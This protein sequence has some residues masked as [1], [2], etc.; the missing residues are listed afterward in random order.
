MDKRV[1]I[2]GGNRG[3]GKAIALKLAED[4]FRVVINFKKDN[5]N[6]KETLKNI[7][8]TGRKASLLQFDVSDRE[9]CRLILKK[10]IE[11]N[12]P[13]YGIVLNAGIKKDCPFPDM[14]EDAWDSVINTD[15][16]SFYN[17]IRPLVMPMIKTRC[18]GRIVIITSVS[19]I[20]G[21]RGQVNYSAAKSGLLGAAKSLALELAKRK[22]T[23]NSVAPG[24]I[25]TEM[26]EDIED[27]FIRQIVPMRRRGRPE[28]VASLVKYLFS[29]DSSYIT[30]QT[31]SVNGGMA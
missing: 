26:A 27:D 4:G 23:V 22:I 15:L 11:E 28:E 1:L 16:D 12:G 29:D 13:F 9:E 7:Q 31:I 6:A 8:E 10:D 3:I 30:G 17:V 18:G 14:D 25:D 21:N 20:T 5:T 19:A 2:T 24:I